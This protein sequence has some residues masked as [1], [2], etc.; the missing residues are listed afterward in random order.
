MLKKII[1]TA[2]LVA[3]MLS[4]AVACTNPPCA[5][6]NINE[7]G[8]CADCGEQVS[9]P[10]PETV[11]YTVYVKDQNNEAAEGVRVMLQAGPGFY[12]YD[13]TDANGVATFD[14]PENK[15]ALKIEASISTAG[16]MYSWSVGEEYEIKNGTTATITVEKLEA[17]YIY[18]K[19]EGGNAIEG[20]QIQAC[21]STGSCGA[22]K[23]TDA[24][25][26]VA[27][28][29]SDLSY[30]SLYTVPSGYVKPDGDANKYYITGTE[31]VIVVAAE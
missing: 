3:L 15:T 7:K 21:T 4:L 17:V 14:V 2:A 6:E 1:S 19:D 9:E 30:A 16:E 20:V 26:K 18:A 25:G 8:V 27:F 12:L 13:N 23:T 31:L 29:M 22:P 10:T 11:T 5:H 28:Y 24:E